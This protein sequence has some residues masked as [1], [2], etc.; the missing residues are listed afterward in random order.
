MTAY[1]TLQ[2]LKQDRLLIIE[3]DKQQVEDMLQIEKIIPTI[4]PPHPYLRGRMCKSL[5]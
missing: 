2:C 3:T 5:Q 1:W 4:D